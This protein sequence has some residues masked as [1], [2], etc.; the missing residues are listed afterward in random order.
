VDSRDVGGEGYD[1][2]DLRAINRAGGIAGGD[3]SPKVIWGVVKEANSACGLAGVAPDDLHR[4]CARLCHESGGELEQ[5]QFLLGNISVQTPER[6]LAVSSAF[7]RPSMTLSESNRVGA[8]RLML[9]DL[10]E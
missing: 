7:G 10:R 9:T 8:P 2:A 5:I 6:Y 3:F 1:R 4:T